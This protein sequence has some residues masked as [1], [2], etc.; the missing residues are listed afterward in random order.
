MAGSIQ[1][2]IAARL[3]ALPADLK[4]V[5]ADASVVGEV[6]WDGALSRDGRHRDSRGRRGA[7]RT[8]R[9][10]S[11]STACAARRWRARASSPSV[12]R[13]PATSPTASCRARRAQHT[14]VAA[15]WL[16]EKA[17]DRVEDLAEVLAHHYATALDLAQAAGQTEQAVALEGPAL[18]FLT[19][20]GDKALNLDLTTAVASFERALAL[21]PP[22]HE[23]RPE[24]LAS[25][26][27]AAV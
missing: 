25:F 1:A 12:T 10:G 24:L 20:A 18:R 6:F 21:T 7:A 11:S 22:G 19:M 2:V 23:R 3:D 17:S 27:D 4:A 13:S 26:A 9:A 16:E 5:L 14:A 15:P 8:G